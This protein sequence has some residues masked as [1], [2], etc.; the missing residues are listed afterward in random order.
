MS[1]VA[2]S[3]GHRRRGTRPSEDS[4]DGA[5]G[6]ALEPFR[7]LDVNRK[8]AWRFYR[9]CSGVRLCWEL[10]EPKGPKGVPTDT[11]SV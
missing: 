1:E 4:V 3:Q 10:E 9:T 2:L 5:I 6:L 7:G 11:E 8:E